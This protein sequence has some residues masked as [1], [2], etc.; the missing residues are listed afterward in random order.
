MVGMFTYYCHAAYYANNG[1][2]IRSVGGSNAYGNFGLV[3]AGSDP[4]EVP[5]SGELAYN[6]VQTAKVYRNESAQFEA[7]EQ[8]N[9]V[10]VYDTDFIP[11][12]EGEIDITF[13]ERTALVSFTG[14]NTVEVTGHGY[15]TGTK[16]TIENTVGVTGLND[17]HYINRVD[18]NTF[19]I[20]S[21]A[22]LTSA[23]NFS[24][25]LSTLGAIIPADEAGTCLLYTSPSPRD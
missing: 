17:D 10:Y 1:S 5:Q 20:F 24:G 18:T 15:E 7:E 21:D 23:R 16:V 25:S 12:P 6:T 22:A 19:T 3:A 14:T 13:A 4:N 8:Q 9:Y 11:L 2:E